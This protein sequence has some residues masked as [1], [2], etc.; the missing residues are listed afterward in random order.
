M[1]ASCLLPLTLLFAL[2]ACGRTDGQARPTLPALPRP[3]PT[4]RIGVMLA[5]LAPTPGPIAELTA[6]PLPSPTPGPTATPAVYAIQPGDTLYGVAD[7][8][9]ISLEQLLALNPDVQPGEIVL[10]GQNIVIPPRP[11][12]APAGALAAALPTS[13]AVVDVRLV[14]TVSGALWALGEVENQ[15]ETAAE[16]GQVEVLLLDQDEEVQA[17]ATTWSA[18]AYLGPGMRGP[19]GLQFS[20]APEGAL[21]PVARVVKGGAPAYLDGRLFALQITSAVL[22]LEG[23]L[24]RVKAELANSAPGAGQG[25]LLVITLYDGQGRV[26]GFREQQIEA[27]L[28][29]SETLGVEAEMAPLGGPAADV[30]VIAFAGVPPPAGAEGG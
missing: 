6:T 17:T 1:R 22:S 28:Q 13:L 16:A 24:V 2:P 15:G 4:P 26:V 27:S 21:R 10:I 14:E 25:I 9:G 30:V 29:P 20:Q 8:N 7:A 12:A 23:E 3:S 5:T 19:F 11:T 18:P